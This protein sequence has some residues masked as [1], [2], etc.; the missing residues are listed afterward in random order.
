MAPICIAGFGF[1]KR[2]INLRWFKQSV[3]EQKIAS[4]L[5]GLSVV[6]FRK[7]VKEL[8]KLS[9]AKLDEFYNLIR[10]LSAACDD[11][12]DIFRFRNVHVVL[13]PIA[14]LEQMELDAFP[15]DGVFRSLDLGPKCNLIF[16]MSHWCIHGPWSIR[17]HAIRKG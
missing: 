1:L 9:P 16:D 17:Y 11:P 13:P 3:S 6:S 10:R 15:I 7:L 8:D 4:E 5:R 12:G 2:V 14:L